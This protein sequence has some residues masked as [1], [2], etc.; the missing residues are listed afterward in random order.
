M[1]YSKS[2]EIQI[3]HNSWCF[4]LYFFKEILKEALDPF[5]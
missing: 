5:Y 4:C 2:A 3:R 1:T